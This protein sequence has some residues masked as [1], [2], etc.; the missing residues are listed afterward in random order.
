[1]HSTKILSSTAILNIDSNIRL[2]SEGSCDSED[3]SNEAITGI[4]DILK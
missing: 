4:N 3:W 2:I 1:M